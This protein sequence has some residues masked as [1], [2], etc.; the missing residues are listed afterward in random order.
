MGESVIS[1][2]FMNSLRNFFN[3]NFDVF[4][5]KLYYKFVL[6]EFQQIYNFEELDYVFKLLFKRVSEIKICYN[7]T[8]FTIIN[9]RA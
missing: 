2:L 7:V 1:Y 5:F 4:K 3:W 8:E 9:E 6:G